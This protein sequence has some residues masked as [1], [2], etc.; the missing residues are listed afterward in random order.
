MR[1]KSLT[2]KSPTGVTAGFANVALTGLRTVFLDH[3]KHSTS[4]TLFATAFRR[5]SLS[6]DRFCS[7]DGG[8]RAGYLI[9]R[10]KRLARG[11]VVVAL[12]GVTGTSCRSE[13]SAVTG[14]DP[15]VQKP[16]TRSNESLSEASPI[17]WNNVTSSYDNVQDYVCLYEKEERAISGG[18]K[19]TI[20][21]SFR[22]PLD[23]RLEWLN[24]RGKVDQMAV[25]RQ[26]FNDGKVLA[27]QSG[28]LGALAGRLRL[29][30]NE[31]LAL[32]DSRHPI[33][34]VGLGKIIERAQKDTANSHI[35]SHLAGEETLDGRPAY[36]FEFTATGNEPVGGLEAAR[37]ALI[38][39][40][41][42]L[43]LPVKLEL[44]DTANTLLERHRFKQVRI[45]Q[46]LSD[47]TFAL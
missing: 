25:Y 46:K 32:S 3:Y 37:K 47:K 28:L 5:I 26:G 45:N 39:I 15:S 10:G 40:D 11:F 42:E 20:R 17:T 35:G 22:K 38:W 6:S 41:R 18:E 44:Y 12:V 23:V 1:H 30:P 4:G 34:E 31:S 2:S 13:R 36:K 7:Y 33:T 8:S 27:R 14:T 43:K 9:R 21:L 16:T 29:D 19:Q 24:D